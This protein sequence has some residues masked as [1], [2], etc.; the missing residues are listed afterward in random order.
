MK[1]FHAVILVKRR[2]CCHRATPSVISKLF[3]WN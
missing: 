1:K 2:P 3:R